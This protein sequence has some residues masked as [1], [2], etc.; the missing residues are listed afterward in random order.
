M[1]EKDTQIQNLTKENVELKT[2]MVELKNQI[3]LLKNQIILFKNQILELKKRLGKNSCNS[4]KPPSSDGLNKP[5]R[6]RSLREKGKNSSGGQKGHK[7]ETL[8][9]KEVPDKIISHEVKICPHC[10]TSLENV[11]IEQIVKRQVFDIPEPRIEVTEHQVEGKICS[12]CNK[13]V[14]AKFPE[15]IKAPTQ[16]GNRLKAFAIY[17]QHQH[18]IPEDRLKEIFSDLFKIP[19]ATATLVKFSENFAK[20]LTG[21]NEELLKEIE[22]TFLK[23]LD[24]TGFRINGKTQWLHVASTEK[25]TYYHFNKKRKSLLTGLKNIVVHDHWKPYYQLQEVKHVL[26]NAHH[27]REL[28]ALIDY[29]KEAWAKKMWRFLRFACKYKETFARGIPRNK[30]KRLRKIYDRIINEGL[31][32]HERLPPYRSKRSRGRIAH[33]TGHNLLFRLRKHKKEVLRFLIDGR[34]P[35]TNNEAERDLRM[36]KLKQKISGGFNTEQGAK[37]FI[38]IRAFMST[39]RKQD[40]DI[41]GTLANAINGTLPRIASG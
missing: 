28:R 22:G 17:L 40:L 16:Y 33:R 41:F 37:I 9:Q 20:E 30:I 23:H 25:L 18:F 14:Q 26:C 31:A 8:W 4:S 38:K 27:L 29:E 35:F 39:L 34:I 15:E 24:E 5:P 10:Q 1:D 36:M 32:Y 2:Q 21:F 7:G 13:Y 12:C 6:T 11:E 19:I 3:I